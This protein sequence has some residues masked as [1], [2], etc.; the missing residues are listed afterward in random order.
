MKHCVHYLCLLL[1]VLSAASSAYADPI[2][3]HNLARAAALGDTKELT[4][5]LKMGANI[6]F[7]FKE[8]G[9]LTPLMAASF[10]GHADVVE[11]LLKAGADTSIRGPLGGQAIHLAVGQCR[12]K[13]VEKL[14][15]AKVKLDTTDKG[16]TPLM[17]GMTE[18]CAGTIS[19]LLAAGDP[20]NAVQPDGWTPLM[21]AAAVG[22]PKVVSLLLKAGAD[23]EQKNAEGDTAADVAT[24]AGHTDAAKLLQVEGK[25]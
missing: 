5:A 11:I 10:S 25:H 7:K 21:H 17:M 19:L 3:D 24:K 23:R 9:G 14:L 13:V 1:L 8:E 18:N 2:A 4:K 12:E 20:V 6:N 16:L 22:S 15:A